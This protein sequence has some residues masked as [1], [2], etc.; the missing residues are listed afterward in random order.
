MKINSL[1]ILFTII[2]IGL[3]ACSKN[4]DDRIGVNSVTPLNVIN[5]SGDTVN[6][7]QNGTRLNIGSNLLPSG[8]YTGIN[9]LVGNQNF[10]FKRAGTVNVVANAPLAIQALT[11]YTLFMAGES[12]DR[13]FL[14]KDTLITDTL[15]NVA[16]L[17]FVNA[18]PDAG[19][20]DVTIASLPTYKNRT[21]GSATPFLSVPSGKV[22][23]SVYRQG[24]TTPL[25]SGNLT[26]TQ[27]TSYTLFSK[28]LVSGT[29]T[30]LLGTRIVVTPSN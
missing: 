14:L 15:A 29:G 28:G 13:V 3:T 4:G 30:N 22:F 18:S 12:T 20:L 26:L 1:L 21:F 7:Y 25:A 2:V 10:Q 17:R 24:V 8:Q 16:R 6:F 11:N 5:A 9:V 19:N 23:Y 27:H